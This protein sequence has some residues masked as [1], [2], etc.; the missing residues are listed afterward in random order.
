MVW[1]VRNTKTRVTARDG[2]FLEISMVHTASVFYALKVRSN[3]LAVIVEIVTVL[4]SVF[5]RS[6]F[7]GKGH[8]PSSGAGPTPL[9][10]NRG[11]KADGR[12]P[13]AEHSDRQRLRASRTSPTYCNALKLAAEVERCQGGLVNISG[14]SRHEMCNVMMGSDV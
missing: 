10:I 4:K 5:T 2:T 12:H 14:R 8:G 13:S 3:R 1:R 11:P 6:K 9:R 7:R